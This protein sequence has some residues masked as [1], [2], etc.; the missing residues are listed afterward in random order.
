MANAIPQHRAPRLQLKIIRPDVRETATVRGYGYAWQKARLGFLKS[1]PVCAA[2]EKQG[3]VTAASVVDHI[4]PHKGDQTLFW[5]HDN[6]QPLCKS[7][8]S[9]KTAATDGGFGNPNK[10]A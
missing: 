10:Q 9:R 7:C 6:W 1:H 8:H 5:D 3:R 2:C 4:T